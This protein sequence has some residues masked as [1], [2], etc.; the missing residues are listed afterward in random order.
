MNE[1]ALH[2]FFYIDTCSRKE[3][4]SKKFTENRKTG[5]I[6]SMSEKVNRL[7][8]NRPSPIE[9]PKDPFYSGKQSPVEPAVDRLLNGEYVLVQDQFSV[10]MNILSA[11]KKHLFGDDK[12]DSFKAYRG[13]RTKFHHSSNYLLAPIK[14]NRLALKKSPDIGWLEKLYPDVE[15]FHLPFPQVQGLNS[16]WQWY[17]KGIKY[18]VLKEKVYPYYGA[19]FPTRFDHLYLFDYWLKKYS[20][21]KNTAIDIGTG[22]GVLSFQLL[23]RGVEKVYATDINPNA[24]ISASEDTER[25]GLEDRLE[26]WQSDLFQVID[27]SAD[28]V[29]FNPPW[30]P[31]QNEIT[32]LDSA[33]YYD[34]GLFER[35]FDSA[36]DYL[37][38]KGRLVILFSNLAEVA[39][40]EV[41]HPVEKE[42]K[43]NSRFEKVK[44]VKRKVVKPSKKTKRRNH[45]TEEYVELW[46]LKKQG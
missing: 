9:L 37:A 44:Y 6:Q 34:P 30:L 17:T 5:R 31:A 45:R 15:D 33:I 24:V 25:L 18:P 11:L 1:V 42:L 19:Y 35:F 14:N 27:K 38:E 4:I 28:L 22:C 36:G 2:T 12:K 29:L 7:K 3:F 21:P 39:G 13:K 10:G 41:D 40:L 32:G 16:A 46:E 26:I 20:G 43:S 8:P 23:N